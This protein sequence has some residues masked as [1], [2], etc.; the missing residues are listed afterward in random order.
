MSHFAS[1]SGGFRPQTPYQCCAHCPWTPLGDFLLD[2]FWT[3]PC[4][5]PPNPG[6]AYGSDHRIIKQDDIF[7]VRN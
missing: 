7:S 4:E 5:L 1:A 6:Y 3:H 2:N